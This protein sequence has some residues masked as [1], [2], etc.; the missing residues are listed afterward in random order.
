MERKQLDNISGNAV[1]SCVHVAVESENML[2]VLSNNTTRVAKCL[3]GDVT[4]DVGAQVLLKWHW[5]VQ[6]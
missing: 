2:K 5:G 6:S 1:F 3:P 4:K